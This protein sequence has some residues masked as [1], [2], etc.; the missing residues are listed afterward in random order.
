LNAARKKF[1]RRHKEREFALQLLYASEFND[2]PMNEIISQLEKPKHIKVTSFVDNLIKFYIE[3]RAITDKEIEVK[4][5][6]WDFN[7]IA[8]IDKIILRMAIVELIYFHDIP[9]EV[10]INEA[11]EL[12]KTFSTEHSGKFINGMLDAIFKKL[13]DENRITKSGR[14][15][16]SNLSL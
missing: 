11:I 15:L 7:R 1:T 10:T 8:I 2:Q 6:N 3:N 5:K 16:I 4:L 14:G 9:P 12:A 13:K